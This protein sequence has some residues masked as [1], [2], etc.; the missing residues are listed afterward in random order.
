MNADGRRL[1]KS[2]AFFDVVAQPLPPG[3]ITPNLLIVNKTSSDLIGIVRWYSAW[4]QFV[5]MPAENT[6]WSVGCLNDIADVFRVAEEARKALSDQRA[7]A[8]IRG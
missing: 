5:L 4:R 7:S 8:C 6:V 1:V 3:R 2:Y